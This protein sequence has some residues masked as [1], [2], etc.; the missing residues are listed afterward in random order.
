MDDFV[1]FGDTREAV[2][3]WRDRIAE[4][5]QERLALELKNAGALALCSDGIAFLGMRVLPTHVL[6]AGKAKRRVRRKLKCLV[7]DH[8]AGAI[9]SVELAQRAT[10]LLARLQHARTRGLR[11]RW[12]AEFADVEA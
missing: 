12:I 6:L 9:E 4:Y 10:A 3:V 8:S 2:V 11:A 1:L 7:R 5:V